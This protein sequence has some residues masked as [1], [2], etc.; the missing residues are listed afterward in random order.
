MS[1]TRRSFLT[2][3]AGSVAAA[4]AFAQRDYSGK[5]PVRYP[6]PDVVSL[7]KR[8]DK[9]K[10]GNSP[11]LRLHT[12]C[13]WAE[14]PA[15][16]GVG[17]Y[18]VW[19][20]IPNDVQLRWLQDDGHVSVMRRPAGN[21]NGN[22]FDYEG[23]QISFEHGNRRVVRYEYNGSITVLA[24][25]FQGKRLNA[26]NDGVVA[27]DGAIWFTDPGYGALMDYEGNKGPLELKEAVYR[28]DKT[29]SITLVTDEI[30]KPNGLCFSPDYKKLY[31]ADTGS[32][33]YPNAPKNIKVWDVVD[34]KTLRNGR[35]FCSMELPGRGAGLADGIRADKEGNIWASAGWVGDGY[36]GVH[37]FAPDGQRIGQIKLPEICSNVCFGGPKRNRLFM[38]A[39]QSIYAVYVEAIGA[40]I[41]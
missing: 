34:G 22:T 28:I 10:I 33:H 7:D 18:L 40:H 1:T 9:I 35:E 30:Y 15:W 17:R 32:S 11:I 13:L 24:D 19:S 5:N 25:K 29:G 4:S 14:G 12:G 26:P 31:V 23:R 37:I 2:A 41:C 27:P 20:D 6:E 39:S 38:T 16:N 8:F 3:A 21:S 36:D